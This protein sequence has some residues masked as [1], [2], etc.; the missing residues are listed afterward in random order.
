VLGVVAHL[1]EEVSMSRARKVK[2][3]SKVWLVFDA[4]HPD[5]S[6]YE[7]GIG[8][9]SHARADRMMVKR[10]GHFVERVQAQALGGKYHRCRQCVGRPHHSPG[11]FTTA[12]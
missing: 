4:P 5:R 1:P 2:K 9:A 7:S 11:P 10:F 8:A 3:L 6:E 12:R